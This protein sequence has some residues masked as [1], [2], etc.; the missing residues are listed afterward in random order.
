MIS[1]TIGTA[2]H[3]DHG[4]TTLIKAITGIETDSLKDE[5]KRG[6]T[7]NLGFAHLDYEDMTVGFVDVPGHEKFIKNMVA[8]VTGIDAVMLVISADEG[9][10][11]QSIEHFNILELMGLKKGFVVITKT[12]LVDEELVEVVEEEV[13]ELVQ[14][15]F[16][17]NCKIIKASSKTMVGI[18]EIKDFIRELASQEDRDLSLENPRLAIDRV[19]SLRGVGTVVTGTLANGLLDKEDT[20]LIYPQQISST[21][22]NLQVFSRDVDRVLAGQRTAINLRDLDKKDLNRGDDLALPDTL[23]LTNQ[24]DCK[25]EII[26]STDRVIKNNSRLHLHIGTK[27]VI[28]KIKILNNTELVGGSSSYARLKIEEDITVKRGDRFI[29]RFY[30]PLETVGGGV[31]LDPNPKRKL[32]EIIKEIDFIEED[33]NLKSYIEFLLKVENSFLKIEE[34]IKNTVFNYEYIKKVL[35]EL[36]SR[37]I[38]YN[39]IF[40]RKIFAIHSQVQEKLNNKILDYLKKN[41]KENNISLG[42]PKEELRNNIF[43]G[44]DK[45]IYNEFI[46]KLVTKNLIKN[47]NN[48]ITT[49]DY[50]P[51]M[52]LSQK[53]KKRELLIKLSNQGKDIL[54][55]KEYRESQESSNIIDYMIAE[56]EL[57]EINK[58]EVI[59][60]HNLENIKEKLIKY[61]KENEK[62]TVVDFRDLIE[63]NRKHSIMILEY[64]DSKNLTKRIEDY[65]ILF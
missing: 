46:D 36:E 30:S 25:I 34:I 24:I 20:V 26:E 64:F 49:F 1:L 7:I 4:K 12:D 42:I 28:A 11:P 22:R 6:I 40:G 41:E 45:N 44:I 39:Y 56:E 19:F 55:V 57:V 60:K 54:N 13:K 31:V 35:F 14:G 18:D 48:M 65:R 53:E 29:L 10:M 23:R 59:L 51:E 50:Y 52:N 2:G 47:T 17:E 27:E 32:N 33:Y 16:L 21:I 9:I 37:D 5:K 58:D 38:V 43:E 8:G 3:I 61:L 15:T 63:S 62:I